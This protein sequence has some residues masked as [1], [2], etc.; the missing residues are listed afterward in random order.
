MPLTQEMFRRFENL[1][2]FNIIEQLYFST[3][4]FLYRS[5]KCSFRKIDIT[6]VIN[7]NRELFT[8]NKAMLMSVKNFLLKENKPG[9]Q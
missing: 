4:Q 7:F 6:T 5:T 2:D 8:S 1:Q 3:Q 9:I